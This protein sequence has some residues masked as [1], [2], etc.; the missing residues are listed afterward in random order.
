[1]EYGIHGGECNMH[2]KKVNINK[3]QIPQFTTTTSKRRAQAVQ[4]TDHPFP[5]DGSRFESTGT[6]TNLRIVHTPSMCKL[7][8]ISSTTSTTKEHT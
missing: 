7:L 1:M 2:L 8:S 6:L 5:V 3:F 4:W